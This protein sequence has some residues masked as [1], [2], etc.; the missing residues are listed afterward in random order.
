MEIR[1]CTTGKGT[2]RNGLTP[3]GHGQPLPVTLLGTEDKLDSVKPLSLWT[4]SLFRRISIGK[5]IAKKGVTIY[6]VF[7]CLSFLYC[8][9]FVTSTV[10]FHSWGADRGF[11]N[12]TYSVVD[13]VLHSQRLLTEAFFG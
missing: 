4:R 2:E 6:Y 11:M 10:Y 7:N 9:S 5:M 8:L 3:K 13:T 12:S 1:F